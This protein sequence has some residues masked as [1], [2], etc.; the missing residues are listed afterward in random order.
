MSVPVSL[1]SFICCLH[2]CLCLCFVNKIAH[3]IA[4][5]GEQYEV[6]FK[7]KN[8]TTVWPNN[9]VI[10]IYAQKTIIKKKKKHA[11]QCSLQHYLQWPGL[12]KESSVHQQRNRIKM[13]WNGILLHHRKGVAN[14][15]ICGN[16]GGPKRLSYRL[17]L[18][19]EPNYHILT[20]CVWKSEKTWIE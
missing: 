6:F 15:V 1:I 11:P 4:T 7:T 9:L 13:W 17:K 3:D 12:R 2:L 10:G 5:T 18:S 8:R 19:Q 14:W 16:M 20:Y